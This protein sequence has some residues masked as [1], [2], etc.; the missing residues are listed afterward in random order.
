MRL[1]WI[2]FFKRSP[3]NLRSVA[4]VPKGRNP[5]GYALF[6]SAYL[7]MGDEDT[8]RELL[9]EMVAMR[10]RDQELACWGYN[11]DWESRAFFVAEG[12]PNIVTTAFAANALLEAYERLGD[13]ESL[14]IADQSGRFLVEQM[15]LSEDSESLTFRYIPGSDVVVH[16]A[17]MLGAGLLARLYSHTNTPRYLEASRKAMHRAMLSLRPDWSWPY[18]E[19][20][21]HQFVDNFHTAYNLSALDKWMR[22][23]GEQRWVAELE[24]AYKYW[25]NTFFLSDGRPK[26]YNDSLYPIDVHCSAQAILTCIQLAGLDERSSTLANSVASWTIENL[27]GGDGAFY[28]QVTRWYKNRIRYIRWSQAWMMIALASLLEFEGGGND[29]GVV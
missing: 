11:F 23:T 21:H 10:C 16:N 20:D 26:Y 8:A 22:Y 12:T 27:Q 5:K 6:A 2:Q 28:Y 9:D 3:I 29:A 25:L 4:L 7:T 13:D 15:V 1:A 24:N 17:Y 19:R 18:G 14:G